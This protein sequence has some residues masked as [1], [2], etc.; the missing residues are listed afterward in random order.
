MRGVNTQ[1]SR[2]PRGSDSWRRRGVARL[3]TVTPESQNAP[4]RFKGLYRG[5]RQRDLA[6]AVLAGGGAGCVRTVHAVRILSGIAARVS[7]K[8]GQAR[9]DGIGEIAGGFTKS[10][11]MNFS[12]SRKPNLI[13][14]IPKGG[15][16]VS[17]EARSGQKLPIALRSPWE[18][19][20]KLPSL[21][22]TRA[23]FPERT[24]L[25][26]FGPPNP[27]YSWVV[28]TEKK[29]EEAGKNF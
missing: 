23:S 28:D 11:G 12:F 5:R 3:P 27:V 26:I 14:I 20:P 24:L 7:R 25:W 9:P 21:P 19:A 29:S 15:R 10:D 13:T 2:P 17:P 16:T 18:R 1:P 22:V 4:S 6:G 8:A